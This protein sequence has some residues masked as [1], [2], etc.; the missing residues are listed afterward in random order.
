MPDHLQAF[1]R[2][3]GWGWRSRSVQAAVTQQIPVTAIDIT[4]EPNT[5]MVQHAMDANARLR[6]SLPK[7]FALDET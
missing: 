7:G 2:P 3:S 1:F 6:K 4:L 5:T